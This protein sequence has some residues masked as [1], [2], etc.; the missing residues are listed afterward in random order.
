[1]RIVAVV[2]IKLNSSRLPQKNI[3]PFTGGE[4][5]CHYVLSTL[6]TIHE[7]DEI[8][9]YCSNSGIKKYIPKGIRYTK[10]SEALDQDSSSISDVLTAFAA[11][12]HADIYLMTHATSPF[13]KAESI[14]QGLVRVIS[15]EN[16]SAFAA[17]KVQ[18][19]L[20]KD[21]KPYNY[22]LENIPRT[23]DL[24][25]LY[26]ETSGF[27]IY[28]SDIIKKEGKRIGQNPYIVEVG[29]IEAIDIDEPED[30][31]IA[32]AVHNHLIRYGSE[33]K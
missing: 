4:P 23:Q 29:E 15:G 26:V 10:R 27:Y 18:D 16:D 20:W 6:L 1:M 12:V 30:F 22:S 3:K 21:S 28:T 19:F 7:I 9:V 8:H 13:I 17:K 11:D 5:L 24:P 33:A 31:F 32:D 2:P 25:A 14:R